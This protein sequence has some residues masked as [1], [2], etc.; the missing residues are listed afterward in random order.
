MTSNCW[1]SSKRE[2][3]CQL[4]TIMAMACQSFEKFYLGRHS[5]RQLTW[6][7]GLGSADVKTRFKAKVHELNVATYALVILLLFQD[8][9]D[10]EF[11]TFQVRQS[12]HLCLDADA[13]LNP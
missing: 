3:K 1:P 10:D 7:L 11:L 12:S 6:Q 13:D 5:G 8:L 2:G 4:P 9:A